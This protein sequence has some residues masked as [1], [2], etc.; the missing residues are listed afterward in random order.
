VLGLLLGYQGYNEH[1]PRFNPA[2]DARQVKSLSLCG[3]SR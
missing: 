3:P 2:L 1:F